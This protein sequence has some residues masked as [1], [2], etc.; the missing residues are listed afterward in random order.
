MAEN[1]SGYTDLAGL[2]MQP[3]LSLAEKT[4]KNNFVTEYLIDFDA[5]AA[6]IRIGFLSSVAVQYAQQMMECPYVR[7]EISRRQLEEPVDPRESAKETKKQIAASLL[8]EAHY[9]GPGSSHSARVAALGKLA[10]INDMD[11]P[12]KIVSDVTHR[13]GVMMVPAIASVEEWEKAAITSQ[14]KLAQEARH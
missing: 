4:L 10:Q 6:A 1:G 5:W 3:E 12:T 11:A 7:R 2:V 9:R 8:R 14:E 13:G